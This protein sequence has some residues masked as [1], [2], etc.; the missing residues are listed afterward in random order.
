MDL[1]VNYNAG[2]TVIEDNTTNCINRVAVLLDIM[3]VND[4]YMKCF[5]VFITIPLHV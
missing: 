3:G 5:L 1:N 4:D 2:L